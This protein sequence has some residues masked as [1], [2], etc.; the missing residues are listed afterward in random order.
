M[1]EICA[2]CYLNCQSMHDFLTLVHTRT[3]LQTPVSDH[4]EL[5]KRL[6]R[7]AKNGQDHIINAVGLQLGE[8]IIEF[9]RAVTAPSADGISLPLVYAGS[10]L[11]ISTRRASILSACLR[12]L[13]NMTSSMDFLCFVLVVLHDARACAR[14]GDPKKCRPTQSPP[15]CHHCP[16]PRTDSSCGHWLCFARHDRQRCCRC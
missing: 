9:H 1:S 16:N 3:D 4:C 2:H 5:T 13:I 14:D 11:A 15:I 6:T 12:A 7:C 10:V 8:L